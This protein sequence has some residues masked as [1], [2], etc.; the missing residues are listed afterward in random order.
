MAQGIAFMAATWGR[1]LPG[2][3]LPRRRPQI[4]SYSGKQATRFLISL[5][6]GVNLINH[7]L[8]LGLIDQMLTEFLDEN[9]L[10]ERPVKLAF[11]QVVDGCQ[12]GDCACPR[13]VLS[14]RLGPSSLSR[15]R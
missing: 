7:L 13:N 4:A 14:R 12:C 3:L 10:D 9:V 1:Y 11:I 8:K 15:L 6:V 5:Q 2:G